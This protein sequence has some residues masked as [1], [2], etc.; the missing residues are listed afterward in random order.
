MNILLN[1][2]GKPRPKF[3]IKENRLAKNNMNNENNPATAK[4]I[5]VVFVITIPT[6][7][8]I[9]TI[10]ALENNIILFFNVA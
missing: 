9:N 8:N 5:D 7:C 10:N 1:V 4:L 3:P 2:T 6:I